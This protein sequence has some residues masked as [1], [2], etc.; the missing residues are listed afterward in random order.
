MVEQADIADAAPFTLR[1]AGFGSDRRAERQ[2][3]GEFS[4]VEARASTV[5]IFASF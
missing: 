2:E 5:S 3:A 1:M 4:L